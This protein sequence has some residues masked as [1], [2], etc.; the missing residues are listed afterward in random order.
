[1]FL[2]EPVPWY[3]I[4]MWF[5]VVAVLVLVNEMARRSKWFSL[6]LFLVLPIVLTV[7]VWPKTVEENPEVGTWFNFVKVYSAL[8]SVLGFLAMR[9]IKGLIA[10]KS[11]LMF[12]AIA[13]AFNILLAVIVDFQV[14]HFDGEINGIMRISGPWNIMNGI[15]GILNMITISGWIGIFISNDKNIDLIWPDQMSFWIMAYTLWNFAFVYNCF[16]DHSFY[17]GAALLISSLIPSFFIKRGAWLQHRAQTL[18]IWMLF[19]MT[20]PAFV[21]DSI[22]A[23]QSSHSKTALWLISSFSL[24]SNM[25]VLVYHL[26]KIIKYK[27][28]PLEE[29]VYIDTAGYKKIVELYATATRKQKT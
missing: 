22:F 4:L 6:I 25:A 26:Y 21:S 18:A 11:I 1:M 5:V 23:V 24:V 19:V 9:F 20:Y 2:F 29:E 28:N 8:L 15:A 17:S 3:L 14:Y 7:A 12:P 16:S 10:N 27:R 13:L